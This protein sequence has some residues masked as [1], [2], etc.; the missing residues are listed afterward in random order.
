MGRS[1]SKPCK[2][3]CCC[4]C[5]QPMDMLNPLAEIFK[6]NSNFNRAGPSG[7][8]GGLGFDQPLQS[9]KQIVLSSNQPN[10]DI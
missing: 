10:C 9:D 5:L 3:P 1:P 6:N 4:V 2:I 7:L 8:G